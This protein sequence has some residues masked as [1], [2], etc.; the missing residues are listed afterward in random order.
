MAEHYIELPSWESLTLTV[1]SALASRDLYFDF[2]AS[3]KSPC[4]MKLDGHFAAFLLS[5]AEPTIVAEAA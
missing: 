4:P 1:E 3:V 2:A 5:C